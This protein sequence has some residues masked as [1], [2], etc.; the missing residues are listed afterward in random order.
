MS[1]PPAHPLIN[2]LESDLA[3]PTESI[4][5][6]LRQT[7]TAINLL[8]IVLWQYGLVTMEQL[9]QIFDWLETMGSTII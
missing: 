7:G 1:L 3:L 5:M 4:E 2:F 8:P 6:G 9:N